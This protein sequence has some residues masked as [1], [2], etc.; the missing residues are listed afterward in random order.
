LQ[1]LGGRV[2]QEKYLFGINITSWLWLTIPLQAM[3]E[4]AFVAVFGIFIGDRMLKEEKRKEGLFILL[5]YIL[6]R[7]IIFYAVLWS[8]GFSYLNVKVGDPDIPSRRD[9]FTIG[10]IIFLSIL[11]APAI[12]WYL[13]TDEMP[14]KRGIYMFSIMLMITT[15]WT[16][17]EW[18]TGQRWIEIGTQ[19]PDGTYLNLR[20]APPLIEFLALTYDVVIEIV[21]AYVPFLAIPYLLGLIKSA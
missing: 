5:I 16:V 10:S 19:N 17:L 8:M 3:S 20:R 15:I 12:Y 13:K 14:R 1:V 2:F 4:A 9:M 11:I 7:Y 18:L 6:V 21:L